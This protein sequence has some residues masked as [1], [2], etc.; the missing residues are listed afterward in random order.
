MRDRENIADNLH[1]TKVIITAYKRCEIFCTDGETHNIEIIDT[2]GLHIVPAMRQLSIKSGKAF[3]LVYDVTNMLS[4]LN[5]LDL[6]DDIADAKGE[7]T[8]DDMQTHTMP[9]ST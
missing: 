2:A 5:A 9:W 6:A 8:K 7:Y 1:I 3:I 4:F